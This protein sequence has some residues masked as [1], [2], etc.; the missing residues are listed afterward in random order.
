MRK[1][2]IYNLDGLKSAKDWIKEPILN[3]KTTKVKKPPL[4][5][6][7][8]VKPGK[9]SNTSIFENALGGYLNVGND[10]YN[11]AIKVALFTSCDSSNAN[12]ISVTPENYDRIMTI[13]TARKLIDSTWIYNNDNYLQPDET[14]SKWEEF[15]TDSYL[16]SLFHSASNQSSLHNLAYDNKTW[17]IKMSFS[18]CRNKK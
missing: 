1:K 11:S 17:N 18:L 4:S 2:I 12:G 9:S 5:N 14:N 8:T 10:V 15:K 7:I 6:A 13:F 3:N 16:Y